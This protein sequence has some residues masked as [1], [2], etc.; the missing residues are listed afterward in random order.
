MEEPS[1][2]NGESQWEIRDKDIDEMEKNNID[3]NIRKHK[4][5]NGRSCCKRDQEIFTICHPLI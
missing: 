2:K 4:S 3:D 1:Q 5:N